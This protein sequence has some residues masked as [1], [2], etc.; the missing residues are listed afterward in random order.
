[1]QISQEGY[2]TNYLE[3]LCYFENYSKK[4]TKQIIPSPPLVLPLQN[5]FQNLENLKKIENSQ[6]GEKIVNEKVV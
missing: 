6:R 1:M 2:F 3:R 5:Q 4:F